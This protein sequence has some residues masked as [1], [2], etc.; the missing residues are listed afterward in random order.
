MVR[1]HSN[2]LTNCQK[3]LISLCGLCGPPAQPPLRCFFFITFL[4]VRQI[5]SKKIVKSRTLV[6]Q[7]QCESVNQWCIERISWQLCHH[8]WTVLPK[9]NGKRI[10]PMQKRIYGRCPLSSRW[11]DDFCVS[12]FFLFFFHP[13]RLC[14]TRVCHCK[15]GRVSSV[16]CVACK[17]SPNMG[18]HG[19][20]KNNKIIYDM[21]LMDI[22]L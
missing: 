22:L 2:R 21:P 5:Y 13:H 17:F 16:L 18:N 12:V 6:D 11:C 19:H 9:Q 15:R 14:V 20:E 1:L 8:K 7:N 3:W 10:V 4:C